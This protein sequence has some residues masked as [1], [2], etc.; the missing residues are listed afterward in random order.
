RLEHAVAVPPEETD[1][2]RAW[3]PPLVATFGNV[4]WIK[5][6]DRLLQAVAAIAPV[7]GARLAIVGTLANVG[8]EALEEQARALGIADR[9]VLHGAVEE[10]EWWRLLRRATVAV[11]LRRLTNGEASGAIAAAQ[12]VGTPVITNMRGAAGEHADG[13]VV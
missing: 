3:D 6:P 8:R 4:D 5:A 9:V 2:E 12:A 13:A 11:Q 10:G 7:T 1:V